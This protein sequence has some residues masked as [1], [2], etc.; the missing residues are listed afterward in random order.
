[1]CNVTKRHLQSSEKQLSKYILA[2]VC[3]VLEEFKCLQCVEYLGLSKIIHMIMLTTERILWVQRI[4]PTKHWTFCVIWRIQ[5]EVWLR[6]HSVCKEEKF[7]DIN[8]V[9]SLIICSCRGVAARYRRWIYFSQLTIGNLVQSHDLT[10]HYKSSSCGSI[11][12]TTVELC[13]KCS[14][15]AFSDEQ[16]SKDCVMQM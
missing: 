1:M 8:Q 7:R 2:F 9:V 12:L 5:F 15:T 10:W 3:A 4:T 13:L 16:V 14:P 11:F 6:L